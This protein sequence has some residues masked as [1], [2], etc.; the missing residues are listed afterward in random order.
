MTKPKPLDYLLHQQRANAHAIE[1]T[2][3]ELLDSGTSEEFQL[4]VLQSLFDDQ[5]TLQGDI[6]ARVDSYLAVIKK[7]EARANYYQSQK[8]YYASQQKKCQD[9]AD[10]M[11][12][13]IA[14]VII[15]SGNNDKFPTLD[16]PNLRLQSASISALVID[17]S[18]PA[19][20]IPLVY[21]K[22]RHSLKPSEVIDKAYVKGI[23]TNGGTLPF[24]KL[25]VSKSLRF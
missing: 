16:H 1:H 17:D 11:R 21:W 10:A 15:D 13:R 8:T 6:S 12:E 9:R 23:L 22:D 20:G 25:E 7:L 4:S 5:H 14:K 18:I 24:A 3:M 2:L 19:A